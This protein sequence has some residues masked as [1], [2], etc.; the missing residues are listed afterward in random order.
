MVVEQIRVNICV[1]Q[2][3]HVYVR[4]RAHPGIMQV[5]GYA[6]LPMDGTNF[7]DC[8]SNTTWPFNLESTIRNASDY[9]AISDEYV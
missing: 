8:R 3:N 6:L 7:I 1:Q 2:D 5:E 9:E 4:D